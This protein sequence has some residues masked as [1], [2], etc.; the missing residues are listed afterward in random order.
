MRRVYEAKICPLAC[1]STRF[2]LIPFQ[3]IK[4]GQ[5]YRAIA[6]TLKISKNTVVEIVRRDRAKKH[7]EE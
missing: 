5:S 1:I 6:I 4:D 3:L 2:W 7:H